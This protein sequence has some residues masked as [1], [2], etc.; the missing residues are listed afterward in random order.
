[1]CANISI[2]PSNFWTLHSLKL[3]ANKTGK[4]MDDTGRIQPVHKKFAGIITFFIHICYVSE[5]RP[6]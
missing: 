6:S 2:Q 4:V 1:M 5:V 3:T